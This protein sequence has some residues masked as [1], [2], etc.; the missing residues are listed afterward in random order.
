[1]KPKEILEHCELCDREM[2]EGSYNEHHL[3]PNTYKGTILIKLHRICHDK[4]H[5][6]FTEYEMW[7]HY[8]TI[9]RLK[10]HPEIDKFI[11]WV[12]KQPPMFYDC[13]KKDTK[14][15]K[16]KEIRVTVNTS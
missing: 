10:E 5:Y 3:I 6:T 8:H 14:D 15:R 4:L 11:K 2:P 13:H 9:A 16:K 7:K 1:M 12:K